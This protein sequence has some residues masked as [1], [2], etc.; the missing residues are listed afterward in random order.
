MKLV[1]CFII[2]ELHCVLETIANL[3]SSSAG[4]GRSRIAVGAAAGFYSPH[5]FVPIPIL[6]SAED[7]FL[8]THSNLSLMCNHTTLKPLKEK[9][10]NGSEPDRHEGC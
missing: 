9:I 1:D 7:R 8:A 6:D 3:P 5:R 2:N 10:R 4:L